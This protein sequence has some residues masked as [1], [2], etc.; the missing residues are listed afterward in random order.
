MR[1]VRCCP[2]RI[3]PVTLLDAGPDPAALCITQVTTPG[4]GRAGFVFVSAPES[5]A[6]PATKKTKPATCVA[7]HSL[8]DEAS[9][10]NCKSIFCNTSV[11]QSVKHNFSV[12][13]VFQTLKN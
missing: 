5:F 4:Q 7:G 13:T 6:L 10:F 1:G 12:N 2:T 8:P 9:N 3:I 11:K